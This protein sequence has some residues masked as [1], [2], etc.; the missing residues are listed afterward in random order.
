[1]SSPVRPIRTVV[2]S[3]LV[4]V[5]TPS[6]HADL[7]LNV[8][9]STQEFFFTGSDT[10]TPFTDFSG[11]VAWS[12]GSQPSATEIAIATDFWDATAPLQHNLLIADSGLQYFVSWFP[13]PS[14]VTANAAGARTSYAT[15]PST[16]IN[17]LESINGTVLPSTL[18]TGFSG[19]SVVVA[20]GSSTAVPEPGSTAILGISALGFVAYCRRRNRQTTRK[21]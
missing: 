13:V 14:S 17:F 16:H 12:I 8:D 11:Q 5:V 15:A 4:A 2:L 20:S 3:L 7:I 6:A 9:T 1:M 21:P 19:L 10:G 18:G